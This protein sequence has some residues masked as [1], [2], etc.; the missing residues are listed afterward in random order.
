MKIILIALAIVLSGCANPAP[1]GVNFSKFL[2]ENDCYKTKLG[3]VYC[4]TGTYR[5][6]DPSQ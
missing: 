4:E 6:F 5:Y 2:Y 1:Q 3:V